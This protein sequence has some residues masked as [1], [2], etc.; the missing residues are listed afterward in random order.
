MEE[1]HTDEFRGQCG[2]TLG[3][4]VQTTITHS[5]A[6][7]DASRE[8]S[9]RDAYGGGQARVRVGVVWR[10]VTPVAGVWQSPWRRRGRVSFEKLSR[11]HGIKIAPEVNCSVEECSLAVGE[12]VGYSSVVSASRMSG[13]V[14]VF[15]DDVE[16]VNTMVQNGVVVQGT[17]TPVTP[18]IRPARKITL[19]NV[20]PFIRD[21][22]LTAELSRYGQPVSQMKMIPL[23]CK[24][25]LLK[26]VV[27]FRR[28]IYMIL[29]NG[30]EEVNVAFKFRIDD[31]DYV[32]FATSDSMKCFGCGQE[33]H[34]R[35][36][37]PEK[38][39]EG[40]SQA[41]GSGPMGG[42]AGQASDTEAGPSPAE[43]RAADPRADS[44]ADADP[45]TQT[46]D[47]EGGS[48]AQPAVSIDSETDVR[49]NFDTDVGCAAAIAAVASVLGE[50]GMDTEAGAE[51]SVFKAPPGKRKMKW[52]KSGDSKGKAQRV[53]SEKQ[54]EETGLSALDDSDSDLSD[55]KSQRSRRCAYT[56]DK[57]KLF[58]QKTKNVKGVVVEDYFPDRRLFIESVQAIMRN[59]GEEQFTV[60]E[61][62]RLKKIVPRLKLGLQTDNEDGFETT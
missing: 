30:V 17:F 20:P 19:S 9:A 41:S 50:E 11:R 22:L 27:C 34:L 24:S 21:D 42:N 23:G 43:G 60:Q 28:Q 38:A 62:Y 46:Q 37:C 51:E 35:R 31:F 33:G 5:Y 55:V 45:V 16:K 36:S 8:K 4:D 48:A 40:P 59:E 47:G 18:L 61:I 57:I 15:L 53:Q 26:H 6:R 2:L 25:P 12:I 13:A 32:V 54:G 1:R 58:L 14:V 7:L 39:E 52:A 3:H 56:F 49:S 44:D 10:G 29:K